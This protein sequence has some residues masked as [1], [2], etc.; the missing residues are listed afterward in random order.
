MIVPASR[1]RIA[2]RQHLRLLW[3]LTVHA[4]AVGCNR[5]EEPQSGPPVQAATAT[6]S[7]T[8]PARNSTALASTDGQHAAAQSSCV[9]PLPSA[10]A[11][12]VSAAS[13]CPPDPGGAPELTR[14][15]VIFPEAPGSP[16]VNVER[17]LTDDQHE[18]GLMYRTRLASDEGMLFKFVDIR[19]RAFWMKNTCIPLD[20]LFI[21]D[22]GTI[23]G[24]VE[25]IPTLNE[26]ERTIPCPARYVLEVNAGYCRSHGVAPGQKVRFED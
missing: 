22:D 14:G 8:A 19:V 6:D 26:A 13:N 3:L 17:A 9:V 20:M 25:Q 23:A 5:G 4:A 16:R 12:A 1:P 18:R 2:P 24:I 11:P 15:Y 10:A 21:A 7:R